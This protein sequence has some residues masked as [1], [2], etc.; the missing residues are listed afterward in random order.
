MRSPDEVLIRHTGTKELPV[1]GIIMEDPEITVVS[2]A[3]RAARAAA[4]ERRASDAMVSDDLP[5]HSD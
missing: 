1:Q 2:D 5:P 4:A 3:L